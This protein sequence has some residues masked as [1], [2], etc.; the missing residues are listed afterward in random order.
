LGIAFFLA[1]LLT[2]VPN[3]KKQ[4]EIKDK[5]QDTLFHIVWHGMAENYQNIET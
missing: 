2:E 5:G 1:H 3:K 4:K